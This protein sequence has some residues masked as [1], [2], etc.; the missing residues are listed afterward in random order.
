[1]HTFKS[2]GVRDEMREVTVEDLKGT[3][4]MIPPFQR[5]NG[6]CWLISERERSNME[7]TVRRFSKQFS[8]PYIREGR[9]FNF[10]TFTITP[11]HV[12]SYGE[13]VNCLIVSTASG[14]EL[15]CL[16]DYERFQVIQWFTRGSR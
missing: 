10:G 4:G 12:L 6:A 16:N 15:P 13:W 5:L 9:A 1:M 2:S 11:K 3:D 14:V 8:L 7:A